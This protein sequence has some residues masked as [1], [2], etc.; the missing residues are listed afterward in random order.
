MFDNRTIEELKKMIGDNHLKKAL[1]R[2]Q[3]CGNSFIILKARLKALDRNENKGTNSREYHSLEMN[4]I[5]DAT[6]KGIVELEEQIHGD[7]V[8]NPVTKGNGE[9]KTEKVS[10]KLRASKFTNEILEKMKKLKNS[11]IPF[12]EKRLSEDISLWTRFGFNPPTDRESYVWWFF[13]C[14]AVFYDKIYQEMVNCEE[15]EIEDRFDDN[16]TKTVDRMDILQKL[17]GANKDNLFYKQLFQIREALDE[18][19]ND[20]ITGFNTNTSLYNIRDN[21]VRKIKKVRDVLRK[22]GKEAFDCV[23]KFQN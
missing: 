15:I 22:Q 7:E 3:D 17:C 1:D 21:F 19:Q 20:S 8:I 2:L 4:K 23:E 11:L 14:Q 9:K 18:I 6:L 13:R 16:Y 12:I 5:R 10:A